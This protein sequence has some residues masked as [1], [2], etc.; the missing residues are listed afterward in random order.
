MPRQRKQCG[1][2]FCVFKGDHECNTD[3]EKCSPDFC[4]CECRSC[5]VYWKES[6]GMW[7]SH[8]ADKK[9]IYLFDYPVVKRYSP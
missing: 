1:T 5:Y 8:L 4:R 3:R 2:C 7:M 6:K 9:G